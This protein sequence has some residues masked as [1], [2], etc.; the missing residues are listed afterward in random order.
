MEAYLAGM[1]TEWAVVAAA[2][3]FTLDAQNTGD[4]T[5][6][7]SNPGTA[8]DTVVFD[9]LPGEGAQRS[10]FFVKEPQRTVRPNEAVSY[11]VKLSIPAGTPAG[12]FDVRGMA[13]SA[14]SA[15]EESSRTSNRVAFTVGVTQAA[16]TKRWPILIAAFVLVLVVIGVVAF[17][18]WPSGQTGSELA[19]GAGSTP[20]PKPGVSR[21]PFAI[22]GS[23]ARKIAPSPTIPD[24]RGTYRGTTVRT[25]NH[26][27]SQVIITLNQDGTKLSGSLKDLAAPTKSFLGSGTVKANGD[28][29]L[30]FDVGVTLVMN[31]SLTGPGR[32]KGT[33]GGETGDP[34]GTWD[35]CTCVH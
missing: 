9:I 26:D 4:L 15:P 14:N 10:W 24:V 11:R 33:Y 8:T 35:V 5:F 29:T 17:V 23:L 3:Q 1:S 13:Y 6:T 32:L 21:S 28:V 27:T 25:S 30:T 34:A 12:S 18:A 16:T 7:V 22:T 20:S 31:G 19:G 2:D